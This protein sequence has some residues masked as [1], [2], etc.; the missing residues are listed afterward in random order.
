MDDLQWGLW[1]SRWLHIGAAMLTVGGA[2]FMRLALLPAAGSVLGDEEHQ[3]LREAV[4][5]R[6]ARVV[7]VC[8]AILLVTGGVNFVT[9]VL[10]PGVEPMPYHALFGVKFLAALGLFMITSLL[11]GKGPAS[12]GIR[13][14]ASRWLTIALVLAAGIV[15]ISGLLLQIRTGAGSSLEARTPLPEATPSPSG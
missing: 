12:S 13:K 15:L 11:L 2:A 4:R 8:I 10:T 14:A 1:L 9:L 7:H 3:R 5:R 6:W